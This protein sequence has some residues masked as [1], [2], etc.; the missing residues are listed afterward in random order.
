[1]LDDIRFPLKDSA[2]RDHRTRFC[3]D[4]SSVSKSRFPH[5]SQAGEVK[6]SAGDDRELLE[7]YQ[8]GARNPNEDAVSHALR[9]IRERVAGFATRSRARLRLERDRTQNRRPLFPIAPLGWCRQ[10][11]GKP[12]EY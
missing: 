11:E 6:T 8:C 12:Y 4:A 5:L 9:V 3:E 10:A 7:K 2:T 1:V